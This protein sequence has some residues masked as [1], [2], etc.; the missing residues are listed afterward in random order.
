MA[1]ERQDAVRGGG[2]GRGKE[3]AAGVEEVAQGEE[4]VQL[5]GVAGQAAVA[6]FRVAPQVFDD[7]EGE[8]HLRAHPGFAPVG[9]VLFAAE[10]HV[11]RPFVDDQIPQ[12]GL[13]A[14]GLERHVGVGAV[15]DQHLLLAMQQV[16]QDL[17]IV[18]V[19]GCV[20]NAD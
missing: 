9:A 17:R 3:R 14:L 10:L 16:G 18:H 1:D 6:R 12:A 19:G 5:R 2:S 7:P 4:Q 11:T 13:P 8:L 20:V 15:G